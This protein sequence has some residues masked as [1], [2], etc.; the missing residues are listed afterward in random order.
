MGEVLRSAGRRCGQSYGRRIAKV[1]RR[2]V[3]AGERGHRLE[4]DTV[5]G[6]NRSGEARVGDIREGV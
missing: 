1:G 5:G 3:T 4:E 2:M 6:V